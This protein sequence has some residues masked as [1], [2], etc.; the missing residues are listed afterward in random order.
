MKKTWLIT[1][2]VITLA[3]LSIGVAV[4]ALAGNGNGPNTTAN[5]AYV[6]G[7]AVTRV[8]DAL[9]VTTEELLTRLQAG[10]TLADIAGTNTDAVIDALVAPYAAHLDLLVQDGTLTQEEAD[11]RLQE[12]STNAES[13]LNI[14]LSN[15]GDFATWHNQMDEYCEPLMNGTGGYRFGGMQNGFGFANGECTMTGGWNE[16]APR[17]S[18]N[19][20]RINAGSGMMK[21]FGGRGFGGQGLANGTCLNTQ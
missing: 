3:A 7:P 18:D 19:A 1:L 12:A 4:P 14:D 21:G 11:A 15:P 6:N 20:P 17:G 2:A 13:F 16:D 5:A 10:E 9:G 8:A